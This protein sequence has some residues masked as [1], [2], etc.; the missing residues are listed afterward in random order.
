MRKRT[1][2][3]PSTT[4]SGG[5]SG[6]FAHLRH[7]VTRSAVLLT[8]ALHGCGWHL[9][10]WWLLCPGCCCCCCGCFSGSCYCYCCY[11]C[12]CSQTGPYPARDLT[13]AP[14]HDSVVVLSAQSRVLLLRRLRPPLALAPCTCGCHGR[15]DA[16]GDH[17]TACS[18]RG[19]L[20]SRT[21]PLQRLQ[22][23]LFAKNRL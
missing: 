23:Y 8:S 10:G 19:V 17:C 6:Y 3:A 14:T 16:L 5:L 2:S 21:L 1:T 18:T 9:R 22:R 13:T 20:A 12:C 15:F 11:C 4:R 7:S